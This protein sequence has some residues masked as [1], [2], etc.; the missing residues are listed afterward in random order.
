MSYITMI[1]PEDNI[2]QTIDDNDS[3]V[4]NVAF[5]FYLK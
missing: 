4:D 3:S 5:D 1:P 2:F